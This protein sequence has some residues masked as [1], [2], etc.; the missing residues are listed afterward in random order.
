MGCMTC[1]SS[2][3]FI[4]H[5]SL[6]MSLLCWVSRKYYLN[7]YCD[8]PVCPQGLNQGPR[9]FDAQNIGDRNQLHMHTPV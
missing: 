2:Y 8:S 6:F 3:V 9:V 1:Y 5:T 4:N 7:H